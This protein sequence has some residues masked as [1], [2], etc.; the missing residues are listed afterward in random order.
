MPRLDR[1]MLALVRR[2]QETH[3]EAV[4]V[5]KPPKVAG[6]NQRK[7]DLEGPFALMLRAHGIGGFIRGYR[8][9]P[10]R[11]WAMDFAWPDRR[12]AVEVDGAVFAAAR[13]GHTSATGI[14]RDYERDAA[15]LALGWVV[16]RITS[17]MIERQDTIDIVRRWV[18]DGGQFTTPEQPE[19]FG[20]RS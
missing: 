14:R 4:T 13:Y 7:K 16:F 12:F 1:R 5:P 10:V 9:H 11:K 20:Q 6:I 8:F 2:V 17:E 18:G 15:A 19:L 3:P